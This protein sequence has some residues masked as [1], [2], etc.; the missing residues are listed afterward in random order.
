MTKFKQYVRQLIVGSIS[1][2]DLEL[3]SKAL[4]K[5]EQDEDMAIAI[6]ISMIGQVNFSDA[7]KFLL[8]SYQNDDLNFEEMLDLGEQLFELKHLF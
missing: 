5:I 8:F 2:G 7:E 1:R 6:G 3:F 4:S